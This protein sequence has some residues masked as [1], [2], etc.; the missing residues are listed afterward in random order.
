MEGIKEK[1]N[2]FIS[3]R[4]TFLDNEYIFGIL[5]LFFVLYGSIIAPTLPFWLVKWITNPFVRTLL[6]FIIILMSSRKPVF[7][8]LLTIGFIVTLMTLNRYD[9]NDKLMKVISYVP[10]VSDVKQFV[11]P[12]EVS[13]NVIAHDEEVNGY[14]V[15]NHLAP[16]F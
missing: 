7:A 5:A 15:D 13:A 6:I 2:M 3:T 10:S 16:L 9:L 1:I 4:T 14:D 8:M 12:A 11:T